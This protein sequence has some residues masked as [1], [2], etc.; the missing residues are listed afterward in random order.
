MDYII[1]HLYSCKIIILIFE[2]DSWKNK[3]KTLKNSALCS[4]L[5]IQTQSHDINHVTK[6]ESRK[7]RFVFVDEKFGFILKDKKTLF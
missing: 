5:D 7:W 1:N 6:E 2:V 3:R 4:V